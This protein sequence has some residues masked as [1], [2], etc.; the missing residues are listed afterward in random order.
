MNIFQRANLR[1]LMLPFQTSHRK[2]SGHVPLLGI[3]RFRVYGFRVYGF[4]GPGV[5]H[6]WF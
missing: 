3:E 4:R 2:S 6:V 5:Q 1:Y